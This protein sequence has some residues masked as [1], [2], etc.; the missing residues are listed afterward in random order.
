MMS[1][2]SDLKQKT[3]ARLRSTK[4]SSVLLLAASL[5]IIFSSMIP[6]PVLAE[7]STTGNISKL[8]EKYFQHDFPKDETADRL[9]RLEQ[10]MFGETRTGSVEERLK[11]LMAL[12]PNLDSKVQEAKAPPE[13]ASAPATEAPRPSKPAYKPA[14]ET[15]YDDEPPSKDQNSY[16]AVSAIEKKILG[17][18]Y[19]GESLG[20][21]LDRLEIKAFGK[22]SA[23]EDLQDR[24]DRLRNSTGI[25]VARQKPMNSEWADEEEDPHIAGSEGIQPFTGVGEDPSLNRSYRKQMSSDYARPKPPAYDPYAGSGTFGAGGGGRGSS[26][27][28]GSSGTFGSGL[29]SSGRGDMPPSAPDFSRGSTGGGSPSPAPALGVSQQIGMLEKEVFQKTYGGETLLNRINRLEV[30]VFPQDK[31]QADK[32]LPDRVSR[33]LAAVPL[34]QASMPPVAPQ[35]RQ[36]KDPDFPDLDFNG[37][38]QISTKPGGLSKI[39]NGLGSALSGGYVGGYNAAPGTL[40]NDPSTG[41]LYDQY[42]GTLIDPM[43]GAVVGRRSVQTNGFGNTGYGGFNSGFSPMSPFGM[44][45]GGSGLQ[46]G[47]GGGGMRFGGWP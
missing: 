36:R 1:R 43:T 2:N 3:R 47:F 41:L 37:P 26:Y 38:G 4:H 29:S 20:K 45:G 24:V 46:F 28:S 17:R 13:P 40:V 23:S 16:P 15:A 32:S 35:K 10:L 18:D 34:S 44:G 5:S 7:D 9:N 39:I 22:T 33:L 42:T 8:E 14:P 30:T 12:V 27:G 6:L 21:R 25:D 19:V 11:N 31:P